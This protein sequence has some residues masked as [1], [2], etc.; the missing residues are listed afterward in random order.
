MWKWRILY[1]WGVLT[2]YQEV[3]TVLSMQLRSEKQETH[4][5]I[6][7]HLKDFVS[8]TSDLTDKTYLMFP[9]P[10]IFIYSN[11]YTNRCNL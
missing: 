9:G 3:S 2:L 1:K 4:T 11:K 7:S 8:D 10:C 5:E 6:L